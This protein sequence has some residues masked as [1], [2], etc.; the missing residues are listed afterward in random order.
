MKKK[1]LLFLIVSAFLLLSFPGILCADNE[2]QNVWQLDKEKNGVKS[3]SRLKKGRSV[4]EFRSISV[5]NYPIEVLLEV[6]ID[7]PS[8][9]KWMPDCLEA[10]ILKEF[11]K[12]LERGNYYI[13]LIY[14]GIWPVKNRDIVME[15]IP[16]TDWGKGVSVIKLKKLDSYPVPMRK[17]VVRVRDFESEFRFQYLERNKTKV[18]FTTYIDVG[19]KVSPKLAAMQTGTVPHKTL[20]N[21]AEV[22][23]DPKYYEAAARDY[24]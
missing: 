24:F 16:K 19:G 9:P 3:Y 1:T 10:T 22:A 11:H 14:D 7:V 20:I 18:M 13:H 17:G 2:D 4:K 5:I 21:M 8:Y 23:A 15:S 12:G 6:I